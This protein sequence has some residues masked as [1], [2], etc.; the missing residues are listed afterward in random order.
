[1]VQHGTHIPSC[2][3]RQGCDDVAGAALKVEQAFVEQNVAS[4][5]NE[6]HRPVNLTVLPVAAVIA[7]GGVVG[8]LSAL[9]FHP[10]I[11]VL[12]ASVHQS[13]IPVGGGGID[14]GHVLQYKVLHISVVA[15]GVEVQCGSGG[16]TPR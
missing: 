2:Q 16:Y 14:G 4:A 10:H 3:C 13:H 15:V 12:V 1:M 9:R 6:I 8:V 5:A 7:R 11:Y